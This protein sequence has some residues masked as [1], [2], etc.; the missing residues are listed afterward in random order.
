MRMLNAGW[1]TRCGNADPIYHFESPRRS[2]ARMDFY[3]ARNK[4]LYAW[5][6]VPF[7]RVVSHLAG[8]TA[9]TLIHTLKPGRF[10][11]RLRGLLA[12]YLFC[13]R[14]RSRRLPVTMET[15]CLIQELKRR[16][17]VLFDEIVPRLED[18]NGI[19]ISNINEC[20]ITLKT[21]T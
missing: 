3:G 11:T 9:K 8:T 17:A 6:N 13:A 15:Y 4:V 20:S 5:H 10:W 1:I 14:A 18:C 21:A 16:G 7:P 2:W 12:G 19:A